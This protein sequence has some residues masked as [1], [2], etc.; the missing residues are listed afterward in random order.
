M[1]S[2]FIFERQKVYH[3]DCHFVNG[4]HGHE[5]FLCKHLG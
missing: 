4:Y 5:L 2:Q 1:G 3:E